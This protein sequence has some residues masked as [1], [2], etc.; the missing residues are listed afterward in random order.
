M[1]CWRRTSCCQARN[2]CHPGAAL[3]SHRSCHQICAHSARCRSG[4]RSERSSVTGSARVGG[5]A[6]AWT[7]R[8]SRVTWLRCSCGL[9]DCHP[10]H[11][12]RRSGVS[13]DGRCRRNLRPRMR[14]RSSWRWWVAFFRNSTAA[15]P[16]NRPVLLPRYAR[17]NPHHVGSESRAA[18]GQWD[19]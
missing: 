19:F 3:K 17:R 5:L 14:S 11:G 8:C 16:R 9:S 13:G 2:G 6:A 15:L 10:G 7:W 1:H 18:P 4:R 12:C